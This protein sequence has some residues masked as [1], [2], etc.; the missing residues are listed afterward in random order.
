MRCAGEAVWLHWGRWWGPW[1]SGAVS[2]T[3]TEGTLLS[4]WFPLMLLTSLPGKFNSGLGPSTNRNSE[5][6][7]L[8]FLPLGPYPRVLRLSLG[9]WPCSV[10]LSYSKSSGLSSG[11]PLPSRRL[12]AKADHLTFTF[13]IQPP[14]APHSIFI[15]TTLA[16][17]CLK[18]RVQGHG[19]E[20]RWKYQWHFRVRVHS[21]KMA[22]A[23]FASSHCNCPFRGKEKRPGYLYSHLLTLPRVCYLSE[24]S[25]THL[26]VVKQGI[27]RSVLQVRKLRHGANI[28]SQR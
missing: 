20:L 26:W 14:T 13:W 28:L 23:V 15:Y 7:V 21:G 16:M 25:R 24:C 1:G 22:L 17:S 4:S 9:P 6:A 8:P 27:R 5:K 2:G 11:Q 3:G 12:T 18:V 19:Q 10:A